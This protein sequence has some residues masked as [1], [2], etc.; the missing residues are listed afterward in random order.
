MEIPQWDEQ[1]ETGI[2]AIDA[3]HR[4]LIEILGELF[5]DG[6]NTPGKSAYIRL[7]SDFIQQITEHFATEEASMRAS[8]YPLMADHKLAH[9]AVQDAFITHIRPFV[10]GTLSHQEVVEFFLRVFYD[11]L[12]HH[13]RKFA[14]FLKSQQTS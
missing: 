6:G 13:D 8:G 2:P 5:Q 4:H 10:Q 11:H 7:T 14:I 1:L 9:R 3:D 12:D